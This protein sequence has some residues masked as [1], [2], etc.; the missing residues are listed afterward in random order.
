[1]SFK[2]IQSL[3]EPQAV[4]VVEVEQP[5]PAPAAPT[6]HVVIDELELVKGPEVVDH[7][8]GEDIVNYAC[9]VHVT[10]HHPNLP[11]DGIQ[12]SVNAIL[13]GSFYMEDTR[14]SAPYG[15]TTAHGGGVY[16]VFSGLEMEKAT[17]QQRENNFEFF[18]LAPE[19][20]KHV[21]EFVINF[22]N[23]LSEDEIE[24]H[25]DTDDMASDIESDQR[26]RNEPDGDDYDG[27]DDYY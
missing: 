25:V 27:D 20:V 4:L 21:G 11:E 1:M 2:L 13:K 10:Y 5:A 24:K 12:I 6:E 22:V 15:S 3:L 7:N 19:Q 17:I 9:D 23:N 26:S 8:K 16:G 18:K 14:F